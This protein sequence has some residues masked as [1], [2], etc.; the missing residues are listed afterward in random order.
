ME[1]NRV[2]IS[3]RSVRDFNDKAINN[4]II[5]KLL[6]SAIMAPSGKNGQPWKFYVIN[7]N[8]ELIK[9]IAELSIHKKWLSKATCFIILFLDKNISYH[10]IKDIQAIGA[11][12][13]NI[14]L[15][16]YELGIGSCWIG[17]I[18]KDEAKVKELIGINNESLELMAIVA[19]GYTNE[20]N[21]NYHRKDLNEVLIDWK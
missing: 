3:R 19:L 15:A 7:K 17:E 20:L 8:S 11:S 16:A 18:L 9:N 5:T 21:K 10:Y 14:L 4:E 12:I 13:H 1:I 2:I 6:S